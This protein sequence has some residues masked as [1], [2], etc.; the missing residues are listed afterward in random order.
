MV[1][2][3]VFRVRA[4]RDVHGSEQ[5]GVRFGVVVQA[6]ELLP[7]STVLI[8]PT[9]TSAQQRSFRPVIKLAGRATRVLV[10]QTWAVSTDR[11]GAS[12]GRL[13][14]SELRD[15]DDALALVFGL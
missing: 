15:V 12:V 9:S 5:R 4:P 14:S 10:E 2:G 11:I 7:L 6:D 8:A 1:R 3:E 13:S